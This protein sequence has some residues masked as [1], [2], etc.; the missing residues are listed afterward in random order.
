MRHSD[1]FLSTILHKLLDTQV[2]S[3]FNQDNPFSETQ[4]YARTCNMKIYKKRAFVIDILKDFNSH[5]VVVGMIDVK[6]VCY[7]CND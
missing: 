4:Q 3:L 5:N 7:F 6:N 1:T 2:L